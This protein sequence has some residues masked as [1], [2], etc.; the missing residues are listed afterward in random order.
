MKR[1]EEHEV[2]HLIDCVRLGINQ[3]QALRRLIEHCKDALKGM[4][5]KWRKEFQEIDV[6]GESALESVMGRAVLEACMSYDE[7]R[8]AAFHSYAYFYIRTAVRMDI[9][10]L[11]HRRSGITRMHD[12]PVIAPDIE[13]GSWLFDEYSCADQCGW[14]EDKNALR[15][16]KSHYSPPRPKSNL[17]LDEYY[18]GSP[19]KQIHQGSFI[20]S[21]NTD[22]ENDKGNMGLDPD[23]KYYFEFLQQTF[24]MNPTEDEAI[25][26]L[27]PSEKDSSTA[28]LSK[29]PPRMRDIISD[30]CFGIN[31]SGVFNVMA[32]ADAHAITQSEVEEVVVACI[33]RLKRLNQIR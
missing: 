32:V 18:K 8:E 6:N 13:H 14:R 20:E 31:G 2:L 4:Y 11:Y 16:C 21:L 22:R 23:D 24:Q 5:Y 3:N 12:C 17:D 15:P 26:S 27:E 9:G 29:L 25:A 30:L 7:T 33:G 28:R 1:L 19:R 10:L